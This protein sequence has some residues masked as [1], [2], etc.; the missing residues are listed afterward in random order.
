MK[1]HYTLG[2]YATIITSC[3]N[4]DIMLHITT[5]CY[6][7]DIVLQLWDKVNHLGIIAWQSVEMVGTFGHQHCLKMLPMA[8]IVFWNEGNHST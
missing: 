8:F 1:S 2:H 4:Y 3:Y 6:N 5:S 7:Y